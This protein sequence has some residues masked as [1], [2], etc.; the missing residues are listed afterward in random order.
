[1]IEDRKALAQLVAAFGA[2]RM[3]SNLNQLAHLANIGALIVNPE[4]EAELSAAYAD[5]R[6]MRRLL[7]LALGLKPG[8]APSY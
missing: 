7:L 4:I 2:S 3:A 1:M 6:E 8:D 5:I